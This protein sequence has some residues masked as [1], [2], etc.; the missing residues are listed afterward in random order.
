MDLIFTELLDGRQFKFDVRFAIQGI[1]INRA[2]CARS[3]LSTC[4]C[5]D[6]DVDYP[7][8]DELELHHLHRAL[9]FVISHTYAIEDRIFCNLTDL[10]SMDVSVVI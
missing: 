7:D 1:V 5:M 6:R 10:S 8:R 2:M 9:D 3:K 4:E